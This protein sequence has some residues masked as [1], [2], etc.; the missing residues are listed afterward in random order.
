MGDA[1]AIEKL[2]VAEAESLKQVKLAQQAQ[3]RDQKKDAH[4]P[5][6][7]MQNASKPYQPTLASRQANNNKL[8]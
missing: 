2:K 5:S 1:A 6:K 3:M 7:V 8:H 4:E